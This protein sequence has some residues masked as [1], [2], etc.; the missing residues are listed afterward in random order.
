MGP[1]RLEAPRA[2]SQNGIKQ[3]ALNMESGRPEFKSRLCHFSAVG[4][5]A[6]CLIFLSLFPCLAMGLIIFT[7]GQLAGA[8]LS[9]LFPEKDLAA[10]HLE[11][12]S[13]HTM[14]FAEGCSGGT[15]MLAQPL[16]TVGAL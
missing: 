11:V 3:R 8:G 16:H 13:G 1:V 2:Q 7:L 9:R 12:H 5:E 6:S 15:E 4:P 14:A 10:S